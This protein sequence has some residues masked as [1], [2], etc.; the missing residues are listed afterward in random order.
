[1]RKSVAAAAMAASLTVGGAAGAALFVPTVSGAQTDDPSADD[2]TESEATDR[3]ERGQF[4][5]EALAPLVED[6]TIDQSQAGAVIAALQE[7][8]PVDL[9]DH[10]HRDRG[11][12]ADALTDV[13]D[14]S[15][16]Q[17]RAALADG[18]TIAEIAEANG[19][20]VDDVVA[21]LVEPA[22]ERLDD[23][24][25]NGRLTEAQASEKLADVTERATDLVNGDFDLGNHRPRR[26]G[27]FGGVRDRDGNTDDETTG[28]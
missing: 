4:L 1:M 2:T 25:E 9:G 26:N 11:F 10:G 8:R 16:D 27:P 23:A 13:L 12:I 3:P 18:Q 7:A 22:E 24:V 5:A 14:I 28:S 15:P 17:L 6:G 21:A 20:S 19:V